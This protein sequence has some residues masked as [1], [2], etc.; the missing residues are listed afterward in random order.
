MRLLSQQ[1]SGLTPCLRGMENLPSPGSPAL[2]LANWLSHADPF[3]LHDALPAEVTFLLDTAY[4]KN[5][6]AQSLA[7]KRK[8]EWLDINDLKA[9]RERAKSLT[10]G[11][12]LLFP[13]NRVSATGGVM[14]Y[15]PG[16][17]QLA[18]ACGLPLIPIIIEGSQRSR[19]APRHNGNPHFARRRVDITFNPPLTAA[20][21]PHP[22][23]WVKGR[24]AEAALASARLDHCLFEQL[25]YAKQDAPKDA[26]VL[27]D[28]EQDFSLKTLLRGALALAHTLSG[29]APGEPVGYL[30]PSTAGS[31]MVFFALQARGAVPVMLNFTAGARAMQAAM[32]TAAAR[33]LITSRRFVLKAELQGTIEALEK[34]GVEIRYTED[35][36]KA[37]SPVTKLVALAAGLAPRTVYRRLFTPRQPQDTAVI[38]FTSGSEG[39]AKG[40][41][42][43]HHNLLSNIAQILTRVPIRSADTFLNTLP[44]FHSSGLTGGTLL[45]LFTGGTSFLYPTPLHYNKI[46]DIAYRAD[47]TILF[48]TDTFLAGYGKTAEPYD[49]ARLRFA[50]AGAEKLKPETR[51]LWADKFGVPLMEGYG[52]TETSPV[53]AVNTPMACKHGTVGQLMPGV[54]WRLKP[55]EGIEQGGELQVKG[56]NI[57]QGYILPGGNG[58][59]TPLPEGWHS[60]GD[61]VTVEEE[62]YATILGRS[63]RFAKLAGEMV[64]LPGV[65]E[66]VAALWPEEQHAVLSV[67]GEKRGETLVLLTTRHNPQR[68][69]LMRHFKQRGMADIALPKTIQTVESLP[70]LGS[71]KVDY[72]TLQQKADAL[73]RPA[74]A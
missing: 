70:V 13:E 42:L 53:L 14:K 49:L 38:L 68:D 21:T 58:E 50:V 71:G 12:W 26:C 6:W 10:T 39:T 15:Y 2:F 3:L 28:T 65:E 16:P 48:A 56:P 46:P 73:A 67:A 5:N 22:A 29:I 17:C 61:I 20:A 52:V 43:S 55:V 4:K 34:D 57:M 7:T 74:A 30:L 45:P 47:A 18:I 60:T 44:L 27:Q 62:G 31:V 33:Q 51:R 24:M 9:C 19:H 59:V 72:V 35:I 32:Q 40:V 23:Q 37:L 41:A 54:Q 25:L 1:T 11:Q 36:R 63:R 64:S 66:A 8:V 69:E